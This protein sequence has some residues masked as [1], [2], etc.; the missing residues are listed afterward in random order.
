MMLLGKDLEFGLDVV[1]GVMYPVFN[2]AF[3]FCEKFVLC[4]GKNS[5]LDVLRET[6]FGSVDAMQF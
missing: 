2:V 1:L 5:V 6:I 3:G 4:K